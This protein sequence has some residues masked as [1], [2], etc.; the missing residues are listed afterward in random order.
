MKTWLLIGLVTLLLSFSGCE[1]KEAAQPVNVDEL[2]GNW[3]L[4]EPGSFDVTLVIEPV[5]QTWEKLPV[6]ILDL[7]GKSAVNTYNSSLSYKDRSKPEI[8]IS[9]IGA[10]KIAGSP[11]EMQFEQT[12]FANLKAVTR[13]ELTSNDRLRLYYDGAQTGTLVYEKIN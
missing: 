4:V 9:A 13:Y 7:S 2:V 8:T 11:D 1:R 10:T 6:Q 3:K 5:I 12:Y